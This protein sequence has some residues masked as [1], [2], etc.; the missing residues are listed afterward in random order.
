MLPYTPYS[1]KESFYKEAHNSLSLGTQFNKPRLKGPHSS[2]RVFSAQPSTDPADEG[3][4][5]T[6]SELFDSTLGEASDERLAHWLFLRRRRRCTTRARQPRVRHRDHATTERHI[7][8]KVS[9]SNKADSF[10]TESHVVQ[11]SLPHPCS[12]E[13]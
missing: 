6:L 10:T 13:T 8:V 1:Y 7:C 4:I 3:T 2:G 12:Q 5:L 9:A 11:F